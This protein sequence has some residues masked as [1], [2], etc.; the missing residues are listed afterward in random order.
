LLIGENGCNIALSLQ[1]LDRRE[2]QDRQETALHQHRLYS[3]KRTCGGSP[4]RQPESTAERRLGVD[5][6]GAG[7][8]VAGGSLGG[9]MLLWS[10][11]DAVAGQ[12]R[13]ISCGKV[14]HEINCSW[15]PPGDKG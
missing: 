3:G 11:K 5:T 1:L 8:K 6:G 7:G 13:K 15:Y 2:A 4:A 10:L 14:I 9:K 12:P